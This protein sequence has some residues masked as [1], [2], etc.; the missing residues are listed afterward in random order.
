MRGR[1]EGVVT[2]IDGGVEGGEMATAK[3]EVERVGKDD[4]QSEDGPDCEVL[5]L[6]GYIIPKTGRD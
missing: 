4:K 3:L 2:T 5:W 6:H 1:K